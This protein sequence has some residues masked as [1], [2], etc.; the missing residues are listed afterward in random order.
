MAYEDISICCGFIGIPYGR[1]MEGDRYLPAAGGDAYLCYLNVNETDGY[2]LK[3][4]IE[5]KSSNGNDEY[6][7]W[8]NRGG[9]MEGP[10]EYVWCDEEIDDGRY[11]YKYSNDYNN[12][13]VKTDKEEFGP[14]N[15]VYNLIY[16]GM[17]HAFKYEKNDQWYV[18]TNKGEFG[19][20]SDISNLHISENGDCL[21][22]IYDYSIQHYC[23]GI[24]L[25]PN[26][27]DADGHN[28][29][30]NYKYDYVVIDGQ[31]FGKSTP[32][33]YRYDEDKK[34]FIWYCLEGPNLVVYE[35]ALD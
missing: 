14:Y 19:P 6:E 28:F 35:Y 29:Y 10:Y 8:V 13:Y 20:Y 32:F 16:D 9:K 25:E 1:I 18:K 23:N 31:R 17:H 12:W 11:A 30:V 34:A 22:Q 2:I 26:N 15:N 7:W 5:K 27:I 24:N 33:E 4:N 3:F 21:Y